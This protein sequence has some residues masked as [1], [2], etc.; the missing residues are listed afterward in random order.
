[1]DIQ[2]TSNTPAL[3]NQIIGSSELSENE[4]GSISNAVVNIMQMYFL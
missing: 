1:M 2:T 3:V 4:N